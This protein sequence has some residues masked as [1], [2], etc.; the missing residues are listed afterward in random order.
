MTND[1]KWDP[2]MDPGTEEMILWETETND[3]LVNNTVQFNLSVVFDSLR[4]HGLQHA[5][6]PCLSLSPGVC[7]NSCPMSQ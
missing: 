1:A 7:S 4:P 5:R 2:E 6:L 3:R